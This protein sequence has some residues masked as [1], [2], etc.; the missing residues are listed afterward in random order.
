VQ[1]PSCRRTT[2]VD[3]ATADHNHNWWDPADFCGEGSPPCDW[4]G[5]GTHTTGTTT[6][7]T[8]DEEIGVAPGAKWILAA[9]C[10]ASDASLLSSLQWMLAPTD[11][12]GN[13]PD[14]SKRP[15]VVNNSWGGPGGSQVFYDV[16]E[17]LAAAGVVPVF[18]AGN[19]GSA[20]GTLGCPA[21][22]SSHS[23][24]RLQTRATRSPLSSRGS[25]P[26]TV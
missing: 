24:W 9:G 13:D 18:S 22:T 3:G 26:S 14:P 8:G 12:S 20:C 6:G 23:T 19:S 21:T 5:H 7:G 2:A 10:C 16:I 15:D 1:Y 4:H 17:A 11:L 25:N